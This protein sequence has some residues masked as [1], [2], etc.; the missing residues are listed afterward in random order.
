MEIHDVAALPGWRGRPLSGLR[1]QDLD[2]TPV[3]AALVSATHATN[4]KGLVI[5]GG[6]VP[7]VLADHLRSRG[8][9]IFPTDPDVPVDVFRAHL[10]TGAELY[11][12]LDGPL[13]YAGTPDSLAYSWSRDAREAHDAYATLL[14]AIHDDSITDALDE[15]VRGRW[16]VGVM[17]G[18]AAERVSEEYAVAAGLGRELASAGLL[19]ATGGGPGAME[20]A[21][22]GA[23]APSEATLEDGLGRLGSVRSFRPDVG[24]WAR[25]AFAVLK[26]FRDPAS[27]HGST[28]TSRPTS[29]PRGSRST[30][31]TPS[32]RTGWPAA[33]PASSC[34]PGR[35]GPCRRCSS[36]RPGSTTPAR[37]PPPP[38]GARRARPVDGD[39]AGGL[40]AGLA[41][42][43]AMATAVHV[44]E[45]VEEA[46]AVVVRA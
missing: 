13:G 3:A 9:M 2:L 12:G 11:V 27:P 40:L 36:S 19:V 4:A 45:T 33:T 1:L 21:N 39:P 10:Y 31:P 35:P 32:A 6:T 8:A 26:A 24:D 28:G 34:C 42:G 41:A 46:V 16:V 14:R 30:S 17:G 22:L 23:V 43:R 15:W 37:T 7:P 5:L 18:H 29:S 38:A 44:V 20:A 25:V